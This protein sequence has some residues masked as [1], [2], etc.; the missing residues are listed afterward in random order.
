MLQVIEK[1]TRLERERGQAM[2]EAK[3][4]KNLFAVVSQEMEYW[5]SLSNNNDD[6]NVMNSMDL[7]NEE[8]CETSSDLRFEMSGDSQQSGVPLDVK[9][10]LP[11]NDCSI[12]SDE[13]NEIVLNSYMVEIAEVDTSNEQMALVPYR[14]ANVVS[15]KE[16]EEKEQESLENKHG[17]LENVVFRE[18]YHPPIRSIPRKH[19]AFVLDGE[20]T[21]IQWEVSDGKFLTLGKQLQ[22]T[23]LAQLKEVLTKYQ[24]AFAWS[25][26]D[27]KG[28]KPEICRHYI[29]L[30]PGT[31]LVCQR[32]RRTNPID[33]ESIKLEIMTLLDARLVWMI[34]WSTTLWHFT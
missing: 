21:T 32:Q 22:G 31:R 28:V 23:V 7:T 26:K 3:Q 9:E 20:E 2:L 34:A 18:E 29:D 5:K 25:Y 33:T 8:S 4:S 6:N 27:L 11:C 15:L 13:Q 14:P 12:V 16:E 30:E 19:S 24:H 17:L 10:P 1:M